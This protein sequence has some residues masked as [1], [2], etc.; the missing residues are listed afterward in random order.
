MSS[1]S[2]YHVIVLIYLNGD[3]Y[4]ISVNRFYTVLCTP[5]PIN[6]LPQ[7]S[8][9]AKMSIPLKMQIDKRWF[10]AFEIFAII[11]D[12]RTRKRVSLAININ[13]NLAQN[14]RYEWFVW[15]EIA[16]EQQ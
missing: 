1:Q 12:F 10:A 11:G 2:E 15:N 7:I 6:C 9:D 5:Q 8:S 16:Q 3:Y 4:K 14:D 13:L